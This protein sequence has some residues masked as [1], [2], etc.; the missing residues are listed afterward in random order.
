M[1]GASRRNVT[2]RYLL[3]PP[4]LAPESREPQLQSTPAAPPRAA[5]ASPLI[6]ANTAMTFGA[7]HSGMGTITH[8]NKLFGLSGQKLLPTSARAHLV[9]C[10]TLILYIHT[11]IEKWL[12]QK[13]FDARVPNKIRNIITSKS[14]TK[15]IL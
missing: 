4:P 9:H 3:P 1:V 10:Y 5:P 7:R 14:T 8:T 13:C 11:P 12:L 6:Y 15:R 2:S